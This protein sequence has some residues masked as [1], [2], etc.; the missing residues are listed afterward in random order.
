MAKRRITAE[1]KTISAGLE[2]LAPSA[3]TVAVLMRG[4]QT[5]PGQQPSSAVLALRV[6][7]SKQDG[8]WLVADVAPINAR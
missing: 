3:A 6:A 4:T 1:A 8:R 2:T 7:L 5:E